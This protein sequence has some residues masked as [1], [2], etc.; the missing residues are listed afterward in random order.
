MTPQRLT[1][2]E[3]QA[4]RTFLHASTRLLAKLDDEMK[5]AHNER[6]ATF[7]VLSNLAEAPGGLLRMSEL[8][9]QTLFSRS[10]LTYT[11]SNLE[12]RGL[13]SRTPDPQDGRGVIATLT[14][15]GRQYHKPL[16]STHLAGIRR[17]FLAMLTAA[18]RADLT[19]A[20]G[21]IVDHLE[22]SHQT[23]QPIGNQPAP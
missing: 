11:V 6:L 15:A 5:Q 20:L 10:R 7:D 12:R 13:V 18:D 14:P 8:A 16:A 2:D 22:P 3:E 21:G 1:P 4:W 23:N 17:H 19:G 9:G